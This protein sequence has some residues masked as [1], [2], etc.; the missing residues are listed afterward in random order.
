MIQGEF[1]AILHAKP[2][3]QCI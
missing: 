3:M 1:K 2:L